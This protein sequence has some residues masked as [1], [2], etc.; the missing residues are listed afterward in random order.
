MS[1]LIASLLTLALFG[2]CC[3]VLGLLQRPV[4]RVTSANRSTVRANASPVVGEAPRTEGQE[5]MP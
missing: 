4:F 1:D 5:C 3:Y 2:T